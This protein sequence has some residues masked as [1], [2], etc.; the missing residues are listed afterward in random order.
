MRTTASLDEETLGIFEELIRDGKRS[1]SKTVRDAIQFYAK[2]RDKIPEEDRID[3]YLEMLSSGEHIIL[4]VDHWLLFLKML[5]NTEDSQ[6]F[7]E[8]HKKIAHSHAEQL[9]TSTEDMESVLK[10]LEACNLFKLGKVSDNEFTLILGTAPAKK[11]LEVLLTEIA[12]GLG[13]KIKIKE[14][15]T[16]LRVEL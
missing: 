9:K 3:F 7:W 5:E 8:A 15:F 12:S 6:E 13:F 16:K 1:R 2:Y 14:D 4:D 11:F 10:R